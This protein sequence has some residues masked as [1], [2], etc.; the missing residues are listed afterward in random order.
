M[1]AWLW[2]RISALAVV[3]LAVLIITNSTGIWTQ[4]TMPFKSDFRSAA[5]A[6]GRDLQPTDAIVFQIPYV[7]YTFDYYFRRPYHVLSGLYTNQPGPNNGYLDSDAAVSAQVQQLL[8]NQTTVWLVW[9]EAS[10]WDQRDLLRRWLNEHGR[11]TFQAE[12]PQVQVTRYELGE[13]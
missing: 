3:V 7:Q 11:V 2:Q 6:I 1:W 12:Y 8:A 4:A 10:M 5:Q 13:K 9:S